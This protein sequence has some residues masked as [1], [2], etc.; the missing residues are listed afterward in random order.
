LALRNA[1]PDNAEPGNAEPDADMTGQ[2]HRRQQAKA[3]TRQIA[4]RASGSS[5]RHGGKSMG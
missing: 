4:D 5:S 3:I 2:H 1:E